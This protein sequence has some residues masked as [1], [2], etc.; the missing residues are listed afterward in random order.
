MHETKKIVLHGS[1]ELGRRVYKEEGECATAV[2]ARVRTVGWKGGHEARLS[3]WP[4][5]LSGAFLYIF[6]ILPLMKK[7]SKRG[8]E[9]ESQGV[10]VAPYISPTTATARA[11]VTPQSSFSSEQ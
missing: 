4:L 11:H 7:R 9:D 6:S 8:G 2:Y 10:L 3:P 1:Q 5:V